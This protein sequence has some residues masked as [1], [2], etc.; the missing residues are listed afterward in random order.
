MDIKKVIS[1]V[2]ASAIVATQ[3]MTSLAVVNAADY[4]AEWTEAVNFMQTEG[5]SST[6]NSVEEY[7]PTATVKR[8]AA[9]KFFVNFAKK[10]FGRTADTTKECTFA[11]INEA[12]PVFVPYIIEACQMGILKGVDGKALP[13]ATLTKLQFLTIL[14]RIV[15]NDS[16]IEPA[17]AFNL[18]KAD[19][20]TKE[21]TLADTVRP[22]TRIELAILFKR[23]VAKYVATQENNTQEE[24]NTEDNTNI[25]DVLGSIL[26]GD[27]ENTTTTGENNNTQEENTTTTGENNNTQEE[28]TKG[29]DKL[30][31]ALDPVTPKTLTV[32]KTAKH[33]KVMKVD[34]T[35]GSKDVTLDTVT[36]KLNGLIKRDDIDSVY[37]TNE[38]GVDISTDKSITSDYTAVLKFKT[39]KVVKA[40]TTVA[41][42]LTVDFKASNTRYGYFT[43]ES[44]EAS[45][46]VNGDLPL[47]SA[48]V[49]LVDYTADTIDFKVQSTASEKKYVGDKNV[50]VY[51]FQ[52]SDEGN[53]DK[54]SIVK[55]I[56]LTASGDDVEGRLDNFKLVVGG[57]DIT[58]SVTIDRDEVTITTK[59]YVLPDG[60]SKVFYVYADVIGGEDNDAIQFYV[61]NDVTDDSKFDLSKD[62]VVMA[63]N[64]AVPVIADS[65]SDVYGK[66]INI[67]EG[68]MLITKSSET[69][70]SSYIPNDE[71]DVLV[72]VANFTA[73]SPL[74]V[75]KFAIPYTIGHNG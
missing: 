54:D 72:L 51:K 9:A 22:V 57:Q 36:V 28:N 43:L 23:A 45:S 2:T 5:L 24:N 40:N 26:G 6:A 47:R 31:V 18:L 15:K 33:V 16:S 49:N 12:N 21:A 56:K 75:K 32:S 27:E 14:A 74:H 61:D 64:A 13:K 11:D 59:D 44:V 66:T 41:Y 69:P 37:I 60:E 34:F 63:D 7:M 29:E 48:D 25:G 70:T 38:S 19:G 52:L 53:D 50:E 68:D 42:Y 46:D 71:N 73:T 8:E 20:I 3:A 39:D 10:E 58:K 1:I 55:S 67:K 17:Q 35:A 30:V 65:L 4:P 62:V